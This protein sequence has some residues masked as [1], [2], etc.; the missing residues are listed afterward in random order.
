MRAIWA[1]CSLTQV[2][3]YINKTLSGRLREFKN[4]G[5]VQLGNPKSGRGHLGD[6]SLQSLSHR[7]LKR[8]FTKVVVTRAGRVRDWSQ[9]EL[10]L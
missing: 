9:E 1:V 3:V 7:Q 4:K 5:K 6:F 2:L 8:D 10:W